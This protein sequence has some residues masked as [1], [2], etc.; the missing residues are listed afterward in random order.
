MDSL[1]RWIFSI[2]LMY[3]SKS[4]R[5]LKK[6]QSTSIKNI[7]VVK[8]TIRSSQYLRWYLGF[9]FCYQIF[10]PMG[11]IT[12]IFR[13]ASSNIQYPVVSTACYLRFFGWTK[14]RNSKE[15]FEFFGLHFTTFHSISSMYGIAL[16]CCVVLFYPFTDIGYIYLYMYLNHIIICSGFYLKL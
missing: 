12:Q 6:D 4:F 14:T 8:N 2:D 15:N 5:R 9:P 10:F 11:E 16:R 13:V 1:N 7:C 3:N